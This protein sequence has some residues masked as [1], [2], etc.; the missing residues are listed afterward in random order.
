MGK[1]AAFAVGGGIILLQVAQ[2]KGYI[3][4]D[5][6]KLKEKAESSTEKVEKTYTKESS[7]WIEKVKK[8]TV[9]NALR[10]IA[11]VFRLKS[12]RKRTPASLL[13]LLAGF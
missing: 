2:Q 8:E 13:D 12:L 5:W 10:K 4:I 6:K 1:T 3:T 11:F 9:K 7:K